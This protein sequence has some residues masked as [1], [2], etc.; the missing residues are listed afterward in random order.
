MNLECAEEKK[1]THK[2][3][4]H[5]LRNWVNGYANIAKGY[6]GKTQVFIGHIKNSLVILQS[7]RCLTDIGGE[8]KSV[9]DKRREYMLAEEP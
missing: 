7:L 2:N 6:N 9:K 5:D 1:R 3:P 4:T 8:W